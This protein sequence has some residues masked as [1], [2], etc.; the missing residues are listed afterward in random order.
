[1]SKDKLIKIC[2]I[3]S[4]ICILVFVIKTIKDYQYYQSTLNSAPFEVWI[5][6]NVVELILPAIICLLTS[7]ILKH[8]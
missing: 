5:L 4:I 6:V 8:K 3:I 2:R 7:V 1:M